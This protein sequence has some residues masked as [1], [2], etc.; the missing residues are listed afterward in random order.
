M[1]GTSQIDNICGHVQCGGLLA[2]HPAFAMLGETEPSQ[3][4]LE[5]LRQ[6]LIIG[7]SH[8]L[9]MH[10]LDSISSQIGKHNGEPIQRYLVLG[11]ILL[12]G[13]GHIL[14]VA[15]ECIG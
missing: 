15:Q 11:K 5:V 13:K 6:S 7:K 10:A 8:T 12:S 9:S 1:G 14:K 3:S 4:V 2:M